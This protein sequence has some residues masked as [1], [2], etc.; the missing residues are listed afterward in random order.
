VRSASYIF[1]SLVCLLAG[2]ASAQTV[3]F[4]ENTKWGIKENEQVLIAPVYDTIFNFDST[5]RV[6]LACFRHK[7]AS[8]NKFIKV[9]TTSYSCNYLNKKNERLIIR[10]T[11][12]DTF[13]VFP[14]SKNIIRLYDHN[15]P[16]FTVS[17]GNKKHLLY[18]NFQQITFRGYHDVSL[19]PE[20]RFYYTH[21]INE[22]DIVLA[23]LTNER[24]EE[25]IPHRYSVIKVNTS[26]SL[27]IACSAGVRN[28]AEDEIFDYEGKK[29]TSTYRHIDLATRNFL[30]HKIFEPREYYILYNMSTKEEKQLSADEIRLHEHDLILVRQK[31]DWYLYDLT[32]HQ[33]KPFKQP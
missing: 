23:G 15:Q 32:T 13:S 22:G 19:S 12:N 25:V 14:L 21:Y 10:N 7:S 4:R 18:K 2:I 6:C 29:I 31:K 5:G 17:A 27:I 16:Y 1:V 20:P 3:P 11:M 9:T 26:D 24:E 33:K 30:I 8:T 28:N